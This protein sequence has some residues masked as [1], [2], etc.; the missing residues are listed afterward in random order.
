MSLHAFQKTGAFTSH[1]PKM[2]F[3]N[4]HGGEGVN[5]LRCGGTGYVNSRT[6][7]I[8]EEEWTVTYNK[9]E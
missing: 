7:H 1:S 3:T 2:P 4:K 6:L 5:V 9:G 8:S